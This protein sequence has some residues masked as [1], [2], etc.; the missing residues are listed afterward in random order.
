MPP[1]TGNQLLS[2][3]FLEDYRKGLSDGAQDLY[4][5]IQCKADY[6]AGSTML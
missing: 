4:N 1:G 5:I 3:L 2:Q 6:S